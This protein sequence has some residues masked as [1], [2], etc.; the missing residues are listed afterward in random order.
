L[1]ALSTPLF[2][3]SARTEELREWRHGIIE[4]K[5][6]AGFAVIPLQERFAAPQGLKVTIVNVQSDG[7]G[8]KAM[9]SGDLDSYE[10]A[11]NSAI[12]A[13]ARGADV[14]IIGCAW[15]QLVQ[16]VFV[17]QDVKSLAD[18]RGKNV[19]ISRC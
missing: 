4:P 2:S 9:L 3:R 10:G 5:S 18:L 15:P 8:L 16:G 1:F 13:G 19:A 14:K 12:V 6:D 17:Q 11:P 7:V